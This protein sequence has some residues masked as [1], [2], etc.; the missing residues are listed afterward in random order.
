MVLHKLNIKLFS[1]FCTF[2]FVRFFELTYCDLTRF[3]FVFDRRNKECAK[4]VSAA[5]AMPALVS[6]DLSG[7]LCSTVGACAVLDAFWYYLYTF[8][9]AFVL[10]SSL[11]YLPSKYTSK[12]DSDDGKQQNRS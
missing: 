6:L 8:V 10:E 12:N 7:N 3:S 9:K 4:V 5:A 2:I 1:H 11:K